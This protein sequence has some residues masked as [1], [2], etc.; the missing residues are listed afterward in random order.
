MSDHLNDK[1]KEV[2]RNLR[3]GI[4]RI[5][6]LRKSHERHLKKNSNP[7]FHRIFTKNWVFQNNVI[8]MSLKCVNRIFQQT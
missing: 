2:L 5:T 1:K 7:P 4:T 3:V 6:T 8:S